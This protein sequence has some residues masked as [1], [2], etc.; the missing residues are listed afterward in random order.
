MQTQSFQ[1]I[2][3]I[4][5]MRGQVVHAKFGQRQRYAPINSRLCD[6]SEALD[7]VAALLKL[8]PF[9]TLYIA[10]IDAI[11]GIGNHDALI[12]KIIN[13]FPKLTIWLDSGKRLSGCKAL[14]V[15]GSESFLNLETYLENKKPHVLSLDFNAQ[16]A[17]GI[18]ELHNEATHWP[19]EVICMALN[20]VGSSQGVDVARLEQIMTLNKASKIY[21]AGGVRNIND[22]QALVAM[23]LS[24]QISGVL[25]ASALHNGQMTGEDIAKFS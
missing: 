2:P 19:E 22:L 21:A 16:G 15:L 4:D 12:T 18:S 9:R 8:Y 23:N 3:V 20:A 7:I 17:M 13:A 14:P 5:L 10:D 24:G 11:L 25:V 1:I 6:S